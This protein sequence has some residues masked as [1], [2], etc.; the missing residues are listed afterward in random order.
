[1]EIIQAIREFTQ[2]IPAEWEEKNGVFEI[3]F[4]IAE[5]K[6]FLSKQKLTYQAKFRIDEANKLIKF[7]E[8]LKEGSA[9]LQAGAGFQVESYNTFKGGQREGSIEEQS[10]QFGKKYS[11]TFD[12]KTIRHK[13]E[14]LAQK[15]GYDFHYQI[16]A[17][18]L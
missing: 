13:V 2:S 12:F 5:R 3:S 14:E 17:S 7:T 11:Y 18:G 8:M 6:T 1:M 16:T 9:G 10:D 15:A 4:T